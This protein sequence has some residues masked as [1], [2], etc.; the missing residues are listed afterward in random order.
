MEHV[1]HFLQRQKNIFKYKFG[2]EFCQ[3]GDQDTEIVANDFE[4]A[5]LNRKTVK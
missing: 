1:L 5:I 4:K 3:N 2:K